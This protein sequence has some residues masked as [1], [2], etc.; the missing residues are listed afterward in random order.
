MG[1]NSSKWDHGKRRNP[2]KLKFHSDLTKMAKE[3]VE[4][5]F[6]FIQKALELNS[7]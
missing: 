3:V 2:E 4:S 5:S 7:G 1:Q 6:I